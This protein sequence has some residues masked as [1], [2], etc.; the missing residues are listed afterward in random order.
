MKGARTPESLPRHLTREETV[1]ADTVRAELQSLLTSPAF[2]NATRL[3]AFLEF[4]VERTLHGEGAQLKEY[5]IALGV[6]NR[7][8]SFE[9]HLDSVVRVEARRLRAR[10]ADYYAAEGRLSRLRI[11]L[12]KGSYRPVF[13][14]VEPERPRSRRLRRAA[15]PLAAAVLLLAAFF[16]AY[17]LYVRSG[18]IDSLLV[19]PLRAAS[20]SDEFRYL[21]DGL[22]GSLIESLGNLPGLRVIAASSA[23]H[24]AAAN[25]APVE[26]ARR[27]NAA[28]VL[29]GTLSERA[30]ALR[31][32]VS[33][34]RANGEYVWSG[35]YQLSPDAMSASQRDIVRDVVRALRLNSTAAARLETRIADPKAEQN[36][37]IGRFLWNKRDPE[38]VRKSV[39]YFEQAIAADPG[40]AQ[41][42][43]ALAATFAV[44]AFNDQAS[45]GDMAPRARLAAQRAIDIDPA[46][47]EAHA[48][49]AWVRFF[50]DR[51]WAAAEHEF[52]RTLD[53]NPNNASALQWYGLTRIA[54][55]R[56]RDAAAAFESAT[57]LDPL[58]MIVRTDSGV[59][60]YY[61]RDYA[62]ALARA[63]DVLA[64]DPGF[65]WAHALAGAA[66]TERRNWSA[67]IPSL[68][69]AVS[70][71]IDDPDCIMRLGVACARSG[72]R[73][74]ALDLASRLE[75]L[76]RTRPRAAYQ[77]AILQAALG[78]TQSA[79]E[80]LETAYNTHEAAIVFLNIDPLLDPLRQTPAFQSLQSR[81]NL[82]SHTR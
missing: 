55:G 42:H 77:K 34:T 6:F 47:A 30:G 75:E 71:A 40:Y 15:V 49:L 61:A 39:A 1:H 4:I 50:Y 33:L 28:A 72:R 14:P 79:Q 5:V 29:E 58:S 23:L 35:A 36:Y 66:E 18:P 25:E 80:S 45:P 60:A 43:A 69:R 19:L 51:D 41:P 59:A 32:A 76:V 21:G 65:Y 7:P 82:P 20:V 13:R 44:M 62:A 74:R 70:L 17:H 24:A 54:L 73:N 81:L 12:P 48:V 63:N 3:R 78:E 68:E 9:P 57:R 38:S 2:H 52:R 26:T 56:T 27:L 37:L 10:L 22:A 53:L 64:I 8:A 16:Y 31:I 46:N 11:E 67:A